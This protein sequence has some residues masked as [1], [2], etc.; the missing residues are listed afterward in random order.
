MLTVGCTNESLAG[1]FQIGGIPTLESRKWIATDV[2]R[3]EL[4][5]SIRT[6]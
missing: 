2:K 1:A 5:V 6:R 4:M 3:L